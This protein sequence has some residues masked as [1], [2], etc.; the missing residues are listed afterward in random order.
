[1]FIYKEA[2]M[3]NLLRILMIYICIITLVGCDNKLASSKYENNE[4]GTIGEI[5]EFEAAE[6]EE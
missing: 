1:M 4:V 2:E 3:K 5:K 6:V